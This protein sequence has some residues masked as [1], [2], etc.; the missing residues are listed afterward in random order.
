MIVTSTDRIGPL[1]DELGEV[2]RREQEI[3]K[4][5]KTLVGRL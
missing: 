5:L 2:Q 1:M 4:E 3:E